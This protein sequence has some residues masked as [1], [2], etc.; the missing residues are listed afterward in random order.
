M[1]RGVPLESR[2][3]DLAAAFAV[4]QAAY[5]LIMQRTILSQMVPLRG[6][7]AVAER[8]RRSEP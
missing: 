6:L 8:L 1:L 7:I 4:E 2:E 5:D 3:Q